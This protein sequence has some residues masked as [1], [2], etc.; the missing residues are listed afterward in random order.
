[1]PKSPT[2]KAS[3]LKPSAKAPKPSTPT[4]PRCAPQNIVPLPPFESPNIN[5]ATAISPTHVK[6]SPKA[7]PPLPTTSARKN[8]KSP[9]PPRQATRSPQQDKPNSSSKNSPTAP[10][11]AKN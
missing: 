3:R 5:L 4:K 6:K 11:S 2:I 8:Y 10:S 1:M 9:S 7:S